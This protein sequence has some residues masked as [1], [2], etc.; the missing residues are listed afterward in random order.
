MIPKCPNRDDP[1]QKF[2]PNPVTMQVWLFMIPK[3]LNRDD[4]MQKFFSNPVTMQI[5]LFMTQKK[6]E[7]RRYHAK[8]LNLHFYYAKITK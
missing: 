8:I 4:P 2:F 5:W 3:C 7:K 1:M 6:P